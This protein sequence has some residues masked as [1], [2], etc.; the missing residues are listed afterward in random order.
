MFLE[1]LFP[2]MLMFHVFSLLIN[3]NYPIER[4]DAPI[5]HAEQSGGFSLRICQNL[6]IFAIEICSTYA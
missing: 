2:S 4:P 6:C 5:T 1:L 3:K